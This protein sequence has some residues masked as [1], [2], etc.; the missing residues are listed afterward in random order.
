MTGI[1]VRII[2]YTV[3]VHGADGTTRTE[4]FRL[5][6]TVLDPDMAPAAE[7][8]AVYHQRWESENGYGKFKTRLRGTEVVLR[9]EFP[10]PGRSGTVPDGR[11]TDLFAGVV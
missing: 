7:L 8:A 3:T 9:F 6:T 11:A 2:R 1:T 5:I 4:P 10:R